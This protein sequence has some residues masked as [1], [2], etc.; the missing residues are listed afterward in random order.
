MTDVVKPPETGATGGNGRA[1]AVAGL[2]LRR[3]VLTMPEVL[4]QCV[5]NAA[6]SAAVSVLPAIAFIYAGNGAWLT[7]VV[8]TIS[9]VLIGY[10][11]SVFAR[12]T[13]SAG[14]FYVY[15]AQSL[16]SAG[17]FASGWA[18]VVGYVFTGMATVCGP[19]IYIAAFLGQFGIHAN[20][21]VGAMILMGIDLVLATFLAYRSISLSA[22]TSLVL[23]AISMT[24]ILALFVVA[25]SEKGLISPDQLSLKGAPTGGIG[26]GIV[27]AIFAF[28]GFESAA[29][30][31][32]EAKNPYKNV[33]RAVI[34]SAV[35]V[36]VFYILGTYA[37]V[38]GFSGQ[39][40]GLDK[41]SAPL[42]DLA[43]ILGV[44][45]FGFVM[46][47]GVALSSFACTLACINAG[48]RILFQMGHDGVMPAVTSRSHATNQTPHIGIY[49]VAPLMLLFPYII[50]LLGHTPIDV[51]NWMG[52]VATF[53]FMLAYLLVAIGAPL[54]LRKRH[55]NYTWPA[56]IGAIGAIVML[57]VYYASIFPNNALPSPLFPSDLT[58]PTELW[59]AI[60][61]VAMIIGM[62]WY[63]IV[64]A[65][66]PHVMSQIGTM[67][68]H[69]EELMAPAQTS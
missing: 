5:A 49:L 20:N 42:F 54:W 27:I 18:L 45:W 31:G 13:A 44:S 6:P 50:I 56:I 48:S 1:A 57:Y 66:R 33:G 9:M 19:A 46:N 40:S 35:L 39:T 4:T 29:S 26:P 24:I 8:A 60:F 43:T 38:L 34:I 52:T 62:A 3:N 22:R 67:Q 47:W 25:F 32:L 11:V 36:G 16:G 23:E 17:G 12:R 65:Q 21:T 2:G 53:G 10:S 63:F 41:A 59:M 28:V 69:N 30:L 61:I 64:R 15:N 37:Q 7:F 14:S 51:I 68:E 55:E 58:Q